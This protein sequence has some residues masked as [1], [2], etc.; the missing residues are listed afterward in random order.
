MQLV[1]CGAYG[2]CKYIRSDEDKR[3]DKVGA[4]TSHAFEAQVYITGIPYFNGFMNWQ[5]GSQ[6]PEKIEWTRHKNGEKQITA[7]LM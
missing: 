1:T 4:F 3:M 2:L 6:L 7:T 5:R